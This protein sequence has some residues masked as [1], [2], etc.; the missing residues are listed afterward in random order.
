[1][2]AD[3]IVV[4][5]RTPSDL[6][7]FCNSLLDNAAAI[8]T[9]TIMDN[10]PVFRDPAIMESNVRNLRAMLGAPVEW[11]VNEENV[12]YAR[13]VN[14]AATRTAGPVLAI[15]NADVVVKPDSIQAM[16]DFL[17]A[18][19]AIGIAG[20]KQV[21]SKG[22]ITHAGVVGNN[23]R[24]EIR[25]WQRKDQ[26]QFDDVTTCISVSGSAYF[27]RR[28]CWDE[29]TSCQNYQDSVVEITG[30]H[31]EGAFLPTPLYYEETFCSLHARKHNWLVAYNGKV[32]MIHEWQGSCR[33]RRVLTDYMTT[34][35]G[36]YRRA[37]DRHDIIRE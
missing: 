8:E 37:C 23:R 33:D 32:E 7:T 4:N 9:L 25:G 27:V 26:G 6:A 19:K 16:C 35:R 13:A 10:A 28:E 20:P 3:V 31:A 29:L 36:M 12:G 2:K 24:P 34:S 18:S 14:R 30:E 22:R 1:M 21:N 15:F 5:Y 17:E 11:I